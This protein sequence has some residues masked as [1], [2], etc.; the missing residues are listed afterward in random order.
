MKLKTVY[1]YD[2]DGFF[3]GEGLAQENQ[4]EPNAWIMP[5]QSTELAP[6]RAGTHWDKFVNGAWVQVTKPQ[7]AQDCIGYVVK[8]ASTTA[9]DNELRQLMQALTYGS[10]TYVLKRGDDLS[11]YVE[12][13]PEEDLMA[14]EAEKLLSEFDA[15]I[16]ELK[17]RLATALLMNDQETIDS[18]R[19]EYNALM[20]GE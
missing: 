19:A 13:V 3:A 8:H 20:L 6:K 14:K 9:H 11:W 2:D 5:P 12:R 10:S 18:V 4:F 1:L 15:R 7:T 17:G 16:S